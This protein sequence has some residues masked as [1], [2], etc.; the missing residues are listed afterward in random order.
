MEHIRHSTKRMIKRDHIHKMAFLLSGLLI[1][2]SLIYLLGRIIFGH[3]STIHVFYSNFYG[4]LFELSEKGAL[5]WGVAFIP[6]AVYEVYRL[7]QK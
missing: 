4:S 6:C 2:P 1:L 3:A 7:M 5:A